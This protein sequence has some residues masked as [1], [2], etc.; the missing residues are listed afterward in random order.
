MIEKEKF[1]ALLENIG[2]PAEEDDYR[3]F[4]IYA[5]M[6]QEWNEKVNLTAITDDEGIAVKHFAD[7]L[8]PMT[9]YDLPDKPRLIDVGTGAGFPSIPMKLIRR[10]IQLTLLDALDKRL[11]FLKHLCHHLGIDAV[12]VHARAEEAGQNP[13]YRGKFDVATCRAVASVSN[14]AEYCLPLLKKG[15]VMLM[16]K[17]SSGREELE[18][19]KD[20]ILVCGG[21][22]E[23]VFDYNLPNG[24]GRTLIV[25]SK[26][27]QTPAR[28][29]RNSAQIKKYPL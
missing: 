22:V 15:G 18:E 13:S 23:Q 16:L 27:S 1:L 25:V 14:L 26:I 4:S 7:S 29:T 2:I 24:D 5:D 10:D 6:L 28:F 9:L 19:G 11:T 20:A 17:G 3:L 21:K 12:T 8:L